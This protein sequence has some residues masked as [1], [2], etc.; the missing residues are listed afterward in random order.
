MCFVTEHKEEIQPMMSI[1]ETYANREH[2]TIAPRLQ[3]NCSYSTPCM[4]NDK[5]VP[6][7]NKTIHLGMG[8]I[9]NV[10]GKSGLKQ[11][12]KADMWRKYP[13][14]HGQMGPIWAEIGPMWVPYRNFSPCGTHIRPL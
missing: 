12:I 7:E 3:Y 9:L 14:T 13:S 2:Y 4:I 1:S 6:C 10:H 8:P 5:T 11:C